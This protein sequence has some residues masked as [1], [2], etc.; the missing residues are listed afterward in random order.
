[1]Q[2]ILKSGIKTIDVVHSLI[3][4]FI[5]LIIAY[6]E[7][8]QAQDILWSIWVASIV[9]GLF[10]Y[11]VVLVFFN[12]LNT[13]SG[14][15]DSTLKI[16]AVIASFWVLL[17][18]PYIQIILYLAPLYPMQLIAPL[19]A[20]NEL[21]YFANDIMA[22]CGVGFIS[23]V[24]DLGYGGCSKS[25]F[26]FLAS[27]EKYY[28]FIIISVL[29]SFYLLWFYKKNHDYETPLKYALNFPKWNLFF[30]S[31]FTALF[32]YVPYFSESHS[33][34]I[35]VILVGAMIICYFFPYRI[36]KPL[37]TIHVKNVDKH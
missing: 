23:V 7:K 36:F 13:K 31:I 19:S 3:F 18:L 29:Q 35:N 24:F 12:I 17:L 32:A 20:H 26:L 14:V 34:K 30:I 15:T 21:Q 5:T 6:Y 1:M 27:I 11:Y 4:F 28:L 33:S 9:S 10:V 25:L 8:W 16:C 37:V 22:L 2:R